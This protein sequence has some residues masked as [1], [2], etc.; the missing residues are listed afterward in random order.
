MHPELWED[1]DP[2][3]VR[4]LSEVQPQLLEEA[5]NDAIYL[6]HYD[7]IL[8]DL[9]R[10]MPPRAETWFSHTYPELVDRTIASFSAEFGLHESLPIYS[11][12]LRILSGAH[13][14]QAS[15]LG[16][17]RVGVGFRNPQG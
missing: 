17:P 4:F 11:G 12:G 2:H 10:Y 14:K 6:Q 8:S 7:S 1:V 15:D 16:L 5:A 13:C 9:D 3:P